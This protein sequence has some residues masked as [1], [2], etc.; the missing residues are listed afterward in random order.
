MISE[1]SRLK[2]V[3]TEPPMVCFKRGKTVKEHLCTAKLPPLRR[4]LRPQE[5]GFRRCNAFGCRLCPFTGLRGDEVQKF[6]RIHTTG[7]DLQ[8]RG[9]LNCKSKNVLYIITCKKDRIQYAGE[10]GTSAEE[11]FVRHRNTVVQSCYQG[12]EL[13]VGQ[14]FQSSG[15]S[16]SDLV[17]TPVEQIFSKNIFVRKVR[18]K[19]LINH[20]DLLRRGLNRNL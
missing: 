20:C 16:V 17:F 14:H 4:S 11:R 8:I 7:E 9:R 12:T 18:E 13:T 10:T 3:F 15:H 1:D 5:D 2:A 6:I 19:K